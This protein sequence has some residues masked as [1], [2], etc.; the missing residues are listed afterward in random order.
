MAPGPMAAQNTATYYF[1]DVGQEKYGDCILAVFPGAT[2]L[3]DGGHASDYDSI[4]AQLTQVL[5]SPA[6]FNISLLVVTHCHSDHIGC[7]PA[8]VANGK[9]H[10]QWA[11]VADEN[12]VFAQAAAGAGAAA[13]AV[14]HVV[15]AK[16]E[17]NHDHLAGAELDSFI[18]DAASL[19]QDYKTM[20]QTLANSGTTVVR[21]GKDDATAL[22]QAFAAAGLTIIGP[23]TNQL[24]ICAREIAQR[25]VNTANNTSAQLAGNPALSEAALY[26]QVGPTDINAVIND[27]SIVLKL[28]SPGNL[29]LFA[30]DM[31]FAQAQ[32]PG[33]APLIASLLASAKAGGPYRLV[34]LTHHSSNNGV[35]QYV[36]PDWQGTLFFAHSGGSDDPDH[37]GTNALALLQQTPGVHFA[38]TDH[39][40]LITFDPAQ[41]FSVTRGA[42]NDF[43]SNGG[44]AQSQ[45]DDQAEQALAG[46]RH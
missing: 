29:V 25:T 16:R 24:D 34:K 37:P 7:L 12:R 30:G 22:V 2:I 45:H 31:Q 14:Q 44:A 26:S 43:S 18:A 46:D 39:N 40:G 4:L 21:Y 5:K 32:V 42:P 1:L 23:T 9:I 27:M 8:L 15:A 35:D 11:L 3:I 13:P 17:E 38:R 28:G 33:L 6:P 36:W 10:V 19:E 20:L 41:G